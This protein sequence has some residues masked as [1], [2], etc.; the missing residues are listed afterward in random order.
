MNKII[1]MP[2]ILCEECKIRELQQYKYKQQEEKEEG[3]YFYWIWQ[4]LLS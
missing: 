1:E 2:K 4:H 3:E